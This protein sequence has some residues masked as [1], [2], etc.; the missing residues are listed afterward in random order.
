MK[1]F[2]YISDSKINNLYSQLGEGMV[3]ELQVTREINSEAGLETSEKTSLLSLLGVEVNFGAAG[4]LQYAQSKKIKLAQK[5]K[6]VLEIL[7]NGNELLSIKR[8]LTETKGANYFYYTGLFYFD[9]SPSFKID[10]QGYVDGIA[11]LS[12][13]L[14]E[15]YHRLSGYQLKLACSSS[16]FS[17]TRA[18][19][20]YQ[21]NSGNYHFFHYSSKIK[22]ETVFVKNEV[23]LETKTIYGSPL[24]LAL[25]SKD[26]EII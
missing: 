11:I 25:E 6:K 16:Y 4:R 19:G 17:D 3:D 14:D 5:L 23:N 21:L 22:F 20:R 15:N 13:D 24:F 1:F 18:N 7:E 26:T 9:E 10:M 2:C 8:I 12:S